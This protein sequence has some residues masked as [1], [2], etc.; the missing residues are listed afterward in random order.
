VESNGDLLDLD[1]RNIGHE[2]VIATINKVKDLGIKQY[3]EFVEELPLFSTSPAKQDSKSH[4]LITAIKMT[5]IYSLA[6]ILHV[7]F[8][9]GTLIIFCT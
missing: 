2:S 7:K 3:N 9:R 4:N 5:E 8:A 1:N 6:S